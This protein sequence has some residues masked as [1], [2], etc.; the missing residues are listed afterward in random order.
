MP[1]PVALPLG[2]KTL[3]KGSAVSSL[4]A[5]GFDHRPDTTTFRR[6]PMM[7]F[8]DRDHGPCRDRCRDHGRRAA[9]L[10]VPAHR[11]GSLH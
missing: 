10:H 5:I 4:G 7:L 9:A 8:N 6:L 1:A 2:R 3:S 11:D